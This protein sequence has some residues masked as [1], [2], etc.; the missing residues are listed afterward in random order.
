MEREKM[1]GD[2]KKAREEERTIVFI[3]E[4][5]FY[6]L[7]SVCRTYA[8][9]G[10]TPILTEK[11]RREH[12]SAIS[13]ITPGGGLY[14]LLKKKSYKAPDVVRFLKHLLIKLSGKLLIIWDGASIHRAR[15]IKDFLKNGA[16]KRLHLEKLPAYAPEL[17]PDE[18][19]WNNLKNQ[20]KNVCCK[21]LKE[22]RIKICKA[23]YKLSR[24]KNKIFNFFR[25]VG[26][27]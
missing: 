5:G 20:L 11:P 18:D 3:D 10:E 13:A 24:N 8:P 6:L 12:L 14:M 2:K 16:S 7:P 27:Y 25:H 1:A 22:L 17:N 19:V 21:N 23:R 9:V 4:A 15:A 26:L